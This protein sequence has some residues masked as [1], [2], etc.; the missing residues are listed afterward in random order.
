MGHKEKG[1]P[2]PLAADP[3][4]SENEDAATYPQK[5]RHTNCDKYCCRI[6][7]CMLIATVLA[8]ILT[9]TV[10]H[11][12]DPVVEINVVRVTKVELIY[13]TIPKPGT[14]L[15][16]TAD[17]SVRNPNVLLLFVYGNTTTTL[18]YHDIVIGEAQG[19]AGRAGPR[20]TA[21]TNITVDVSMDRLISY[22]NVNE[23]M[24][25]GLLTLSSYSRIPGGRVELFKGFKKRINI[26]S[27]NCT[28]TFN[29]STQAIEEQK[30]KP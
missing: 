13:R 4:S 12:E 16:L 1:S 5:S 23:D 21:R 25:S 11:I 15:S 6:T 27:M 20:R 10:F 18:Y 26:L 22:P 19:P 28:I 2:R 9:F 17:V 30:C 14:N 8:I 7:I 3:S 29:I 24:S